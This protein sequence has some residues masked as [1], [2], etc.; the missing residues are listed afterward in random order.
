[1][2]DTPNHIR[3][4]LARPEF[5]LELDLELPGR[6]ITAVFGASGSGKTTLWRCVAG[7]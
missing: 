4:S 7:L 6:G 5:S 1:M 3:L 2:S